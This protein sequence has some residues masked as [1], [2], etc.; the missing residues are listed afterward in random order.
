M[1][2]LLNTKK[3]TSNS[4]VTSQLHHLSCELINS[5]IKKMLYKNIYL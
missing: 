5:D 4:K 3:K 1:R 2:L